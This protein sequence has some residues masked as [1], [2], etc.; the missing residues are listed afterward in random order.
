MS[1][2]IERWT[3]VKVIEN[4]AAKENLEETLKLLD[5]ISALERQ[6]AKL[7]YGFTRI[8]ILKPFHGIAILH[9]MTEYCRQWVDVLKEYLE[10]KNGDQHGT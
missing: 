3:M 7:P 10:R 2:W 4:R 8:Y 9:G 6:I 5:E 1:S